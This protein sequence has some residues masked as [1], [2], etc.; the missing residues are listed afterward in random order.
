MHQ[1]KPLPQGAPG[2]REAG[3]WDRGHAGLSG[4]TELVLGNYTRDEESGVVQRGT[5]SSGIGSGEASSEEHF[6]WA[7]WGTGIPLL[8]GEA[9]RAVQAWEH[10]QR[11]KGRA[12]PRSGGKDA[13]CPPRPSRSPEPARGIL[14]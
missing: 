1:R 9:Q 12:E 13:H 4:N 2:Q 6:G 7:M 11:C 8:V 10:R 14:L 5:D 3:R